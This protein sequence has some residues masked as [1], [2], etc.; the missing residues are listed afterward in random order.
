MS[1][2]KQ[3][4]LIILI[5][6]IILQQT[7]EDIHF[8][9]IHSRHGARAPIQLY[10]NYTDIFGNKWEGPSELTEMGVK[11]HYLIGLRNSIVYKKLYNPEYKNKEILVYSTNLNRTIMSAQAQL[12]G[13]YNNIHYN[14]NLVKEKGNIQINLSNFNFDEDYFHYYPVPIHTYEEKKINGVTK[15]ILVMDYLWPRRC[16]KNLDKINKNIKNETLTKKK[17]DDMINKYFTEQQKESTKKNNIQRNFNLVHR[18]C[19]VIISTYYDGKKIERIDLDQARN[20]CENFEFWKQVEIE[21]S[22]NAKDSGIYT[23]SLMMDNLLYWMEGRIKQKNL[24]EKAGFP[25]IVLYMGHD[26]TLIAMQ[27]FLKDA[28]QKNISNTFSKTPFASSQFFELRKNDKGIYNV[29]IFYDD[30][31]VYEQPFSVFNNS[32]RKILIPQ[33][34][35]ISYCE[36][37]SYDEK[38]FVFLLCLFVFLVVV[39]CALVYLFINKMKK[40][41][42]K[43]ISNNILNQNS[44]NIT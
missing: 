28:L 2:L 6:K 9:L 36:G 32:V 42:E 8:V 4:I 12:L 11:Q 40:V 13:M 19:D 25:K 23:M 15:M 37:M 33:L 24:D 29:L 35:V 7:I 10:S 20:D 26:T 16:K 27:R 43:N 17:V 34:N 1:F 5:S 30:V 44:N 39:C 3:N 41:D 18:F 31:K 38:I 14:F 22:Y 21:Q